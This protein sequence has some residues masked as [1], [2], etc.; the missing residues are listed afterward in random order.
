MTSSVISNS[1]YGII[2]D[3]MHSAGILGD[4]D[5]PD[6]ETLATYLGR[7][8]AARG[9]SEKIETKDTTPTLRIVTDDKELKEDIEN[10]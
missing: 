7:K 4:G 8:F 6:S 10:V 5:T 2:E 9:Y 1:A 3:A